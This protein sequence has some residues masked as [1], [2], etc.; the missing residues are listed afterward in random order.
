MCLFSC[1]CGLNLEPMTLLLIDLDFL[2]NVPAYHRVSRSRFSK[3][4]ALPA[5]TDRQT[6]TDT[7]DRTHYHSRIHSVRT[8]KLCG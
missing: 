1:S 4:T 8:H 7:R 2:E 6:D 3:V 5:Q